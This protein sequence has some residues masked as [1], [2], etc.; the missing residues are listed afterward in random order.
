MIASDDYGVASVPGMMIGGLRVPNH[1]SVRPGNRHRQSG[2][3]PQGKRQDTSLQN[4]NDTP[5]LK[6]LH[7]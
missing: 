4:C 3:G 2:H 6:I 1:R 5:K 7:S